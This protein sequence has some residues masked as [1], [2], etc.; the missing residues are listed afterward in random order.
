MNLI[1]TLDEGDDYVHLK[2]AWGSEKTVF[3]GIQADPQSKEAIDSLSLVLDSLVGLFNY[4]GY[5][6]VRFSLYDL[7]HIWPDGSDL[8]IEYHQLR[9]SQMTGK[10]KTPQPINHSSS[11][12]TKIEPAQDLNSILIVVRGPE[13]L[14][15]ELMA[16]V[17]QTTGAGRKGIEG[18]H[19]YALGCSAKSEQVEGI[20]F[21][22]HKKG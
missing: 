2:E 20:V 13:D 21:L 22:S 5:G 9:F 16:V 6:L 18:I 15:P 10:S 4:Y 7:R 8:G 19:W 14:S 1:I 3:T 17:V 11:R 12:L